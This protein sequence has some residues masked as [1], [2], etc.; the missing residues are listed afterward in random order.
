MTSKMVSA[1]PRIQ[2]PAKTDSPSS[3]TARGGVDDDDDDDDEEATPRADMVFAP[4]P[5]PAGA[6]DEDDDDDATPRADADDMKAAQTA[7][8]AKAKEP[9][10]LDQF[11]LLG[12]L[13]VGAFAE[14][15]LAQRHD[16]GKLFALK[17]FKKV[18]D[19]LTAQERQEAIGEVRLLANLVHENILR[20][21]DSFLEGG[22][23]RSEEHT[24]ELQSHV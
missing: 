22:A 18:M 24:S 3:Q 16:D 10:L 11:E 1:M 21:E 4:T 20:Y 14:C 2:V 17:K 5:G 8:A 13:G 6:D 12:V 19:V 7:A 15:H 23:M 9:S